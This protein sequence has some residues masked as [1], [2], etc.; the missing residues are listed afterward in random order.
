MKTGRRMTALGVLTGGLLLI[1]FAAPSLAD[2][3]LS[4]PDTSGASVQVVGADGSEAA[5]KVAAPAD[6]TDP[7][8][9]E[10][11]ATSDDPWVC[12]ADLG[13]GCDDQP[14]VDDPCQ[15]GDGGTDP[16]D[17]CNAYPLPVGCPGSG[18]GDGGG[19]G[20]D[21]CSTYPLPAGCPGPGGNGGG[22]DGHGHG[23]G[24]GNGGTIPGLP[25]GNG[26]NGGSSGH[27]HGN[28]GSSG[29]NGAPLAGSP[30]DGSPQVEGSRP[31]SDVQG[32]SDGL[33]A[34]TDVIC[35]NTA[36]TVAARTA[37][38]QA[39]GTTLPQTGAAQDL[40]GVALVGLLLVLWGA[41]MMRPRPAPRH[42]T[43]E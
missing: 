33:T 3:G 26:G 15:P 17:P 22:N 1:G 37:P 40:R 30:S 11:C 4:G 19:N 16:G 24:G 10:D 28:G 9:V 34:C 13:D 32:V 2:T 29:G 5:P 36:P 23:N 6:L 12:A 42:R 14:P 27:H 35:R 39:A 25:G 38:S 8:D 20:G 31:G 18:G 43:A 21:P 41:W 7:T